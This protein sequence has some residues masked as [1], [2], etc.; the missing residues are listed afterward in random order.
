M[1]PYPGGQARQF[2][3]VLGAR[4]DSRGQVFANLNG[5]DGLLQVG[6]GEDGVGQRGDE[7]VDA[8]PGGAVGIGQLAG[9]EQG[10]VLVENVH[11]GAALLDFLE[12]LVEDGCVAAGAGVHLVE[13]VDGLAA[14]GQQADDG[15][16]DAELLEDGHRGRRRRSGGHDGR[17]SLLSMCR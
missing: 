6:D 15:G 7:V 11:G 16:G 13:G 4:G 8:D 1:P 2:L 10:E 5:H 9:L 3:K 14:D 12:R 17:L